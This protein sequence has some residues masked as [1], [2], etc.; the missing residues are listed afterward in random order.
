MAEVNVSRELTVKCEA[1]VR[2]PGLSPD[3]KVT[4]IVGK[5]G[6]GKILH[7]IWPLIQI[8]ASIWG[9]TLPPLPVTPAPAA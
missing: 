9:I 8:L 2:D 5:I 1:I 6:D 7:A 3:E 4:A